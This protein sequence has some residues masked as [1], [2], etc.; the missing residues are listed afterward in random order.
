MFAGGSYTNDN[1]RIHYYIDDPDCERRPDKIYMHKFAFEVV[2][3][4]GHVPMAR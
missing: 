4:P 3:G 1:L 2:Q